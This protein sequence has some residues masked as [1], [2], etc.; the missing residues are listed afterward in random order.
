MLKEKGMQVVEAPD[1]VAF[2]AKVAGLKDMD[3]YSDPKVKAM[4]DKIMAA[5]R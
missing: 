4:L 5:A 1:I 2:R 3:L